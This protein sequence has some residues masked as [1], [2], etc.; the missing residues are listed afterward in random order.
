[1]INQIE[2]F[3]ISFYFSIICEENVY[4]NWKGFSKSNDRVYQLADGFN[5]LNDNHIE[6][7]FINLKKFCRD[8]E[9]YPHSS[10]A[11]Y[12]YMLD[13]ISLCGEKLLNSSREACF[14]SIIDRFNI[15]LFL[16]TERA[17]V[18]NNVLFSHML[19]RLKALSLPES[20]AALIS[21][22]NRGLLSWLGSEAFNDR[23]ALILKLF[24]ELRSELKLEKLLS[25]AIINS[26]PGTLM[27]LCDY[28]RIDEKLIGF[29]GPTSFS[30]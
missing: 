3:Q 7:L 30:N 12:I 26:Y 4:K 23:L 13:L 29:I 17:F 27:I 25:I 10:N 21:T 11:L 9:L 28:I 1:M 5:P 18:N 2:S 15:N 14:D 19:R 22:F 8:I 20:K 24:P 6:Q 16:L